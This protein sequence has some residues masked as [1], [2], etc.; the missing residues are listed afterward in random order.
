MKMSDALPAIVSVCLTRLTELTEMTLRPPLPVIVVELLMFPSAWV[1]VNPAASIDAARASASA[2][3]RS[4]MTM[5]PV[6]VRS[7][8]MSSFAVGSMNS[9]PMM[10][11]LS[12]VPVLLG[13]APTS[14]TILVA[15]SLMM[16]FAPFRP[17]TAKLLAAP[18]FKPVNA[19][20]HFWQLLWWFWSQTP[21]P[22]Q[23]AVVQV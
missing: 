14:P 20:G 1:G 13:P 12:S 7:E 17:R 8:W 5:P 23:P 10:V 6:T 21:W 19:F 4:W 22:L 18:R 9:C 15:P 2:W 16:R 3:V 11:D